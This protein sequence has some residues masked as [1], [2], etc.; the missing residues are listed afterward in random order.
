MRAVFDLELHSKYARAVS[1]D[2]VPENMA[3]WAVKKGIDVLGTGDF[4]HP[5]W[6]KEL[7]EKLEPAEPGLF[8][9]KRLPQTEFGARA[10]DARFLLQGEISCIYS[11][12]GRVRRV[13]QLVYAPSFEVV[14]KINNKLNWIGNL[15]ADG[16]PMLGLDSKK[17]LEIMLE[18]SPEAYLIPAHAWTPWF[19]IFGSK[20]GFDSLEEC[21][22][23]LTPYVFAIETGL[24]SDPPMNWRIPFLDEKAIVSGSDAH[25]LPKMGREATI[26]DVSELSYKNIFDAIKS[27][28]PKKFLSTIE[29]FPEEGKYHYDGHSDMGHSQSPEETKKAGGKCAKCGNSVVV[30]VMSRVEEL[31][32]K[33]RPE[34]H[35]DPKRAPFR[36]L[37]PLQEIIAEA[38]G[39]TSQTKNVKKTYEDLVKN[40][41]SE[42]KILLESTR[43]EIIGAS[44]NVKIA[45]AVLRVRE[46][47]IKIEPGYDGEY[48]KVKIF[49]E[50]EK[51][52]EPQ[53]SLF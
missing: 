47:K 20:S 1:K 34:G 43:E 8:K 19:G 18:A 40:I 27:R 44:G 14:E 26:V 5:A 22:D 25:S 21:F 45:E 38:L 48:G 2:M 6:F 10:K 23:E 3:E 42:F 31:A 46:G 11:K 28:D 4:T 12:K 51:L 53:K 39:V 50:G 24:S 49:K 13:H 36:K 35:S 16:R 52:D 9:L 37:V 33:N 41:G 29:F 7:K 17:L 15:K 30:G 32:V